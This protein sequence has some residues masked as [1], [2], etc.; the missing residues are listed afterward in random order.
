MLC[1][2]MCIYWLCAFDTLPSRTCPAPAD[3]R[4]LLSSRCSLIPFT[5]PSPS[6]QT[7]SSSSRP[8]YS[9][10][11]TCSP[12]CALPLHLRRV[13]GVGELAHAL[14]YSTSR[15]HPW[16]SLRLHGPTP[17]LPLHLDSR[18]CPFSNHHGRGRASAPPSQ[19]FTSSL[20]PR[21][22]NS[23][24]LFSCVCGDGSE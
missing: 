22:F 1:V 21:H 18:P 24:A 12:I 7:S 14:R 5:Q 4:R 9:P 11:L 17:R 8:G 19:R 23:A 3:G 10:T 20:A 16:T 13:R 2:H 6:C 15:S